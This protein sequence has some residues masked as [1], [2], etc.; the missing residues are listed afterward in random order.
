MLHVRFIIIKLKP[1]KRPIQSTS[2][3]TVHRLVVDKGNK[4]K[5]KIDL[6]VHPARKILL[7]FAITNSF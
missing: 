3:I 2:S 6:L 4:L 7:M 1:C 5:L